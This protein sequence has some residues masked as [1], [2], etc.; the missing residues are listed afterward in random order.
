M[1]LS[2][3]SSLLDLGGSSRVVQIGIGGCNA[4]LRQL[5]PLRAM[6]CCA[7]ATSNARVCTWSNL[8]QRCPSWPKKRACRVKTSGGWLP[9]ARQGHNEGG[10]GGPAPSNPAAGRSKRG[11]LALKRFNA[12]CFGAWATLD[13]PTQRHRHRQPWW[14]Y[15]DPCHTAR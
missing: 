15:A 14:K 4:P 7:W 10:Q 6:T 1:F 2:Q 13:A 9:N 3:G 11:G 5:G 8:F 12:D